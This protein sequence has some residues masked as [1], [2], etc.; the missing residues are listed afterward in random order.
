MHIGFRYSFF[1]QIWGRNSNIQTDFQTINLKES[2]TPNLL[3][4]CMFRLDLLELVGD[5]SALPAEELQRLP[6]PLNVSF[7]HEEDR[8]P[9][10]L[11]LIFDF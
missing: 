11:I 5:V 8:R 10:I 9:L 7:R 3:A 2:D 4:L 6:G 1:F